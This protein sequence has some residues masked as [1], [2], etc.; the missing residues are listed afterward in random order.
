M[1]K[2]FS[3][4]LSESLSSWQAKLPL[5]LVAALLVTALLQVAQMFSLGAI[6][7]RELNGM[8]NNVSEQRMEELMDQFEGGDEAA[9]E[10]LFTE[11]GLVNEDGTVI[12]SDEAARSMMVKSLEGM[13]PYFGLYALLASIVSVFAY[14]MYIVLVLGKGTNV[15][16]L[17][18]VLQQTFS[19]LPRMFGISIWAILRSFIW[20]PII[21]IIPGIILGPRFWLAPIFA[22]QNNEGITKSVEHSYQATRGYWGKLVGNILL[23][24]LVFLL[25]AIATGIAAK[26]VEAINQ[27][28]GILLG[29]YIAQLISIFAAFF[30]VHLGQTIIKN[31]KKS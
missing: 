21:G 16:S 26:I 30:L 6:D 12:N 24:M 2:S 14:T 4:L 17:G 18:A 11:M 19:Y 1:T 5:V 29:A 13:A 20:I 8:F 22:V 7:T 23:L 25:V 27:T 28:L 15:N 9:L 31:P 3:V 10:Q